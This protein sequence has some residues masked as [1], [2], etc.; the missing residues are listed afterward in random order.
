MY[1]Y[2]YNLQGDVTHLLDSYGNVAGSYKYDV[3]G[4]ATQINGDIAI[5]NPFRYRGYYYDNE[6]GLYYLNSRYYNPEWGRFLNAD[7]YVSTGQGLTG[8]NLFAYCG[9]N[10]VMYSDPN[11]TFS[12]SALMDM[13]SGMTTVI[14]AGINAIDNIQNPNTMG[15]SSSGDLSSDAM[16]ENAE[17]IFNVLSLEGWSTNAICAVL[18]NMQHESV[19]INPGRYQNGGGPGYGIVQWDPASKYLNWAAEYGYSSDSL[20]GQVD[21]LNYSM[22]PGNGEWFKNAMYSSYYLSYSNFITSNN[23]VAYLT[24]VFAW[25]YERPD[26]AH[27]DKRITYSNYWYNYFS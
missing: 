10:P 15:N 2:V 23:D 26:I 27:M 1:Y 4:N 25:S 13:L 17:I 12:M 21:F 11:G 19:T 18:G 22:Q 24:Q 9:N 8:Y 3:W 7:G 20:I 5:L 14:S 6:S 16:H